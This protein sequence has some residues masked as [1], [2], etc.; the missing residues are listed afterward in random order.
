MTCSQPQLEATSRVDFRA[1]RIPVGGVDFLPPNLDSTGPIGLDFGS[2]ATRAGPQDLDQEPG[3]DQ[4]RVTR[5]TCWC[6]ARW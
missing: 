4:A 2:L 3:N 1:P 6:L 5:S